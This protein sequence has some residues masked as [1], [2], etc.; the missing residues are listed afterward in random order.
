[1]PTEPKADLKQL[2]QAQK[3]RLRDKLREIQMQRGPDHEM[4]VDID[5]NLD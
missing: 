4:R 2:K 5:A 3:A 1:M